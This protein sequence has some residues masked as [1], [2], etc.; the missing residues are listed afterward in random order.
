MTKDAI[1]NVIGT[2]KRGTRADALDHDLFALVILKEAQDYFDLDV[3]YDDCVKDYIEHIGVD[4]EKVM[5]SELGRSIE[6]AL[7]HYTSG[8][9]EEIVSTFHDFYF[10]KRYVNKR[11]IK[12]L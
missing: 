10:N 6:N 7:R 9:Q 5:N 2:V 11:Y 3:S 4:Y 12:P 1:E 8:P